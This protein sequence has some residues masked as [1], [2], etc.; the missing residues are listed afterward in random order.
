MTE[1]LATD[2]FWLLDAVG[3]TVAALCAMARGRGLAHGYAT[4]GVGRFSEIALPADNR[5]A[6]P[7]AAPRIEFPEF[8]GWPA[9]PRSATA[10]PSLVGAILPLGS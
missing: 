7:H 10:R 5:W 2:G 9:Q 8:T 4:K 1:L 3:V 6:P